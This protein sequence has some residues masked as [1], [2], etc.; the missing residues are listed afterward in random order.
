MSFKRIRQN[1]HA[2]EWSYC[3][4]LS[5]DGRALILRDAES[6]HEAATTLEQIGKILSGKIQNGLGK[7]R[8]VLL[9]LM[10][11]SEQDRIAENERLFDVVKDARNMAVHEG[12]FARH[13]SSRLIDLFLI[14]EEAIM[15]KLQ[16]VEDIMVRNPVV[17]ETWQMV[18]NA[19]RD[20]LA[21]SFSF[22]PILHNG[23]WQLIADSE[24]MRF[25]RNPSNLPKNDR[26][27]MSLDA[28]IKDGSVCLISVKT[29]APTDTIVHLTEII[30]NLP[31][32]VIKE[33]DGEPKLLGIVTPF[34]LL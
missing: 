14:L 18:A 30:E 5:R 27:S 31:V 9:E 26:L 25:L 15:T 2:D 28:T 10:K 32:L 13:L 19:R 7:Y 34:D 29:C 6:F 23:K 24:V 20:L 22:L 21:N 33:F 3:L 1:I 12:S 11:M 16:C 17:A 4:S 8:D